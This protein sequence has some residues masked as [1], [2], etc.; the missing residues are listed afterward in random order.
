M[1]EMK[2]EIPQEMVMAAVKAQVIAALGKSEQL[3]EGVVSSA[4]AQ[5]R[6]SYNRTTI[7]EEQVTKMIREVAEEC[8][9]DW[10][11]ENKEKVRAE[12]KRQLAA[13]KGKILTDMVKQFTDQLTNIYARVSLSFPEG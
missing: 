7:F 11:E 6:E 13:Q 1:A 9:R 4:L 8:F 3:I 5:K 10:L 12:M 2:L